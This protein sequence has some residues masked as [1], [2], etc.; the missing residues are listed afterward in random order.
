MYT[1]TNKTALKSLKRISSSFLQLLKEQPYSSISISN[2]CLKAGISR[3]TFYTLFRTKDN[4][5]IYLLRSADRA[6]FT[7]KNQVTSVSL[8]H[9]AGKFSLYLVD[10]KELLELLY[11]NRILYLLQD[12][13]FQNLFSTSFL[14]DYDPLKRKIC[15]DFIAGGLYGIAK[16]YI[17]HPDANQPELEKCVI[18]LFSGDLFL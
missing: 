1:G 4:L 14:S 6:D 17:E 3:Q 16:N 10:N 11:Q 2:V 13:L 18:H 9:I 7:D 5:V 15:L 8:P 12:C